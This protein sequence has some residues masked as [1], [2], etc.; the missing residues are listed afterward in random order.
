MQPCAY[1]E[2][3]QK[4][5]DT[6]LNPLTVHYETELIVNPITISMFEVPL[7]PNRHSVTLSNIKSNE[8]EIELLNFNLLLLLYAKYEIFC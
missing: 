4:L 7:V 3:G 6:F 2:P 8:S 1:H 5:Y